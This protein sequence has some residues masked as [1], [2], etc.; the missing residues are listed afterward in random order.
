V[1][2]P[3]L[4]L[5]LTEL[6]EAIADATAMTGRR[7]DPQ[8]GR[9]LCTCRPSARWIVIEPRTIALPTL[10]R[11]LKPVRPKRPVICWRSDAANA[12]A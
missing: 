6:E 8:T 10:L 1:G 9:G 12:Y 3:H 2:E 7:G 11:T 4:T 5:L